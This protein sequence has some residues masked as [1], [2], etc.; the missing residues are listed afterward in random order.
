MS[1]SLGAQP[2]LDPMAA[3]WEQAWEAGRLLTV[4]SPQQFSDLQL[5]HPEKLI[6]LMCKSHAC[7]PC[8]MFT[9]KYLSIVSACCQLSIGCRPLHACSCKKDQGVHDTCMQVVSASSWLA[10]QLCGCGAVEM[11]PVPPQH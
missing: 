1:A 4:K 3:T 10:A 7:R 11:M 8:K 6:V 9:R 5:S 2:S